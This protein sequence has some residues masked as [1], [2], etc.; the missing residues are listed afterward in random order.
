MKAQHN[1]I[2]E[3]LETLHNMPL[4]YSLLF[5]DL[6]QS[7]GLFYP[8]ICQHNNMVYGFMFSFSIQAQLNTQTHTHIN[9]MTTVI[10]IS[11]F[12]GRQRNPL[13]GGLTRNSGCPQLFVSLNC[14]FPLN[15]LYFF[16]C[17]IFFF[18]KQNYYTP[19]NHSFC[20]HVCG[21]QKERGKAVMGGKYSP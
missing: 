1:F 15:K 18:C 7:V 10:N 2:L 20:D 14:S 13:F 3:H 6:Q 5:Y 16:G 9:T 4:Q 17:F 11:V 21:T 8:A 19:R 12:F